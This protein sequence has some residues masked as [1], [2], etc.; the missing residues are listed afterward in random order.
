MARARDRKQLR[1]I[2]PQVQWATLHLGL[3]VYHC[4]PTNRVNHRRPAHGHA[5]IVSV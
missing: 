5:L 3:I 4:V 2:L 1:F